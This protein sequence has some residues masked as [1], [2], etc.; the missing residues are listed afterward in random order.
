[1]NFKKIKACAI[2]LSCSL[3]SGVFAGTA[4]ADKADETYQVTAARIAQEYNAANPTA[5]VETVKTIHWLAR[6]TAKI[7][8]TIQE[9]G[10]EVSFEAGDNV[11][12]IQR[13]YHAKAGV[14]EIQVAEGKTCYIA[15]TYLK[16]VKALATGAQGDYSRETKLAYINNQ[17]ITSRTNYLIWISLD[18]QRVNVFVGSNGNWQLKKWYKASSGAGDSPTLDQ[19]FN[20]YYYVKWKKQAVGSMT[21]YTSFYGS[22]IHRFVGGGQSNMGKN[23]ISQSCVRVATKHAKWIYKNV[24]LKSRVWIW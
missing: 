4:M 9:T 16:W 8:T 11:T 1:M 6:T 21:W 22:G 5:P 2:A 20:S 18:K 13:D 17:N 19:G 10:E 15:N 23:P 3:I 7:K 24:P 12:V 14:S